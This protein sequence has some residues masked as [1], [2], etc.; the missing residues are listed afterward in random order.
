MTDLPV[1]RKVHSRYLVVHAQ[2]AKASDNAANSEAQSP[3]LRSALNLPVS[4]P[5]YAPPRD[6]RPGAGNAICPRRPSREA[7]RARSRPASPASTG[8]PAREAPPSTRTA[9]GSPKGHRRGE[10]PPAHRGE[11]GV[12]GDGRELREQPHPC[13]AVRE[14]AVPI[15][16]VRPE[17]AEEAVGS[18]AREPHRNPRDFSPRTRQGPRARSP[19]DSLDERP[20]EPR[21]V[22]DDE[23]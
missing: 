3:E 23:T 22:R 2:A 17:D 21:V 6:L 15:P 12:T 11:D 8:S 16:G 5:R 18:L 19:E 9:T 7:T 14:R 13:L 4:V 20:V 10:R 1:R